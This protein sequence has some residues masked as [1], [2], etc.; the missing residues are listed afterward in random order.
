MKI[1]QGID[2]IKEP[3]HN[4]VVTI[5]NFDGVHKGHQ[6]IF[7]KVKQK[8]SMLGGS[9]VAV[10]FEPHPL[11][12]LKKDAAPP[13]IT[14]WEQKTELISACGIDILVTIK[15]DMN[16]AS[17]EPKDFVKEILVDKIGMKAIVIGKD[18]AFGKDRKGDVSMLVELGASYGFEVIIVDWIEPAGTDGM[19]ISSTRIR[20]II[21]NGLVEEAFS[22][23]G[24]HYQ[25]RGTVT[26]G[27]NRG[28]RL[29]GFPTANLR[30]ADELCPKS[31]VYAVTVEAES[32]LYPGVANIGYSPTFSDL[33]FTVE[34][35][36]LDFSGDLYGRSIRVNFISRIR[37][38]IRF[39]SIDDLKNQIRK[40]IEKA[41]E[42]LSVN[43]PAAGS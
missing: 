29:L 20:E 8:A 30:L 38:E 19:R 1:Y 42:I 37:D 23:L 2:Q 4:A 11:K 17:L 18:Y 12:V 9:S 25:L 7:N 3:F 36:I 28:G 22:Y 31:G 10:T 41:R 13:L 33:V 34:V 15:F 6:A 24:R 26:T 14:L 32:K 5:G 35:H 21:S 43:M 27:R 40:D 39:N 16:F